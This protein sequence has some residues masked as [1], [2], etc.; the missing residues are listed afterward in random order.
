M[1]YAR[2][3]N[4]QLR[5]LLAERMGG[6]R[7]FYTLS[8]YTF[9]LNEALSVWQM[10]TG[11]FTA[12]YSQEVPEGAD[13]VVLDT[14]ANPDAMGIIRIRRREGGDTTGSALYPLTV[15]EMDQE[16]PNRPAVTSSTMEYWAPLGYDSFVVHPPSSSTQTVGIQYRSAEPK[17]TLT[18]S[19]NIDLGDEDIP[20]IISYAHWVLAFKEGLKEAFE[21]ASPLKE[22]F[23]AAARLRNQKLRNTAPYRDYLAQDRDEGQPNRSAKE[24]EGLLK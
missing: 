23:M 16:F 19:N 9:A 3:T 21:N 15:F 13:V 6:Q 2:T 17:L 11:D 10:L 22:I 8:E 12:E 24:Q 5:D 1:A 18:G 7:S 20:A 4:D 14:T